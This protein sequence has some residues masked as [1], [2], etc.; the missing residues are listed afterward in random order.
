MSVLFDREH[1]KNHIASVRKSKGMSQYDLAR[2]VGVSRN[3]ISNIECGF[4]HPTAYT[5]GLICRVLGCSF[6]DLFYYVTCSD[7]DFDDL[8]NMTIDEWLGGNNLQ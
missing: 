7:D 8:D 5:A 2:L 4:Y 3:S 6:E 1:F